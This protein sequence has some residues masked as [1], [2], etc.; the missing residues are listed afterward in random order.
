MITGVFVNT[1]VC[2]RVHLENRAFVTGR[3]FMN[4]TFVLWVTVK[5]GL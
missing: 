4:A 2:E 5:Y 1:P 3:Y